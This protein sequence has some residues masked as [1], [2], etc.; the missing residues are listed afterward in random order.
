M[1]ANYGAQALVIWSLRCSFPD[2]TSSVGRHWVL[3]IDG[4]RG[5]VGMRQYAVCLGLLTP[6]R[7]AAAPALGA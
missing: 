6:G 3:A 4:T 7:R 5:F 2:A 1:I